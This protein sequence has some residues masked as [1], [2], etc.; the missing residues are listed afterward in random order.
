MCSFALYPGKEPSEIPG[1]IM[2]GARMTISN[3]T[4]RPIT[5]CGVVGRMRPNAARHS[6]DS[7]DRPVH[8]R[9]REGVMADKRSNHAVIWRIPAGHR[10]APNLAWA[11]V[12]T[13]YAIAFLQRVFGR[14]SVSPS[15]HAGISGTDCR[16]RCDARLRSYFLGLHLDADFQAGLLVDRYG[17]KACGAFSSMAG[18]SSAREALRFATGAPVLMDVFCRTADRLPAAIALVFTALVEAGSRSVFTRRNGSA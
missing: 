11:T 18:P 4:R 15:F 10:I 12:A 2:R 9:H 1:M 5:G 13:A 3:I 16:R 17:V 6:P 8:G 14:S 7:A